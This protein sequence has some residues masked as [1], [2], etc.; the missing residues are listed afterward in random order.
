[1]RR[2]EMHS[3]VFQNAPSDWNEALPLGNGTFG[4]MA[5]FREGQYW[6]ALNHY[7]V[8]YT[9]YHRYSHQ[10]EAERRPAEPGAQRAQYE[11]LME[12]SRRNTGDYGKEEYLHYR[13]T[14][15]PTADIPRQSDL[16]SGVSHP[17][18]GETAVVLSEALACPEEYS[19]RLDIEEAA[20]RLHAQKDGKQVK[21]E[22]VVLADRS[23]ACTRVSQ[24]ESGLTEKLLLRY[25]QRRGH[26]GFSVRWSQEG[27]STFL[28]RV[29]FYPE[30]E[31]REQ[32]PPFSFAVVHHLIGAEGN[33]VPA[34]GGLDV[35]LS[36]QDREYILLS[37]AATELSGG[38]NPAEAALEEV[39]NA[40]ASLT[41]RLKAHRDYWREFFG[42]SAVLLPDKV[43]ERLWYL[44]LYALGCCS[45]RKGCRKEQASGLNGLWDIR[46]PTMWGSLWYWDVNIE[47]TY[48]PV[49]T[50][51]HLELAE[52]FHDGF[53][54]YTEQAKRRAQE[55]YGMRGYAMDYP[56][57]FYNCM[58]PWCAQ[59]LWWYYEY[60]GDLEFLRE[61]AYPV[62]Y[63]L[64][65]FTEDV[66][67]YDPDTGRWSFFP[68]VSPEQG[69]ITRN[70]TIT[71]A[72]V[73]YMLK[74]ALQACRLLNRPDEEAE[75]FRRLLERM[76]PYSTAVL[77]RYGEVLKDSELAPA[78]LR[79]RH[80]SL[81]MPIFPLSELG[82]D[83]GGELLQIAK[84][85]VFFA[86]E[87]T[88]IGVFPFGWIAAAAARLGMGNTALRILYEQ[89]LDL[90]L[91]ANGMGAEET[92]RWVNKCLVNSVHFYPPFMMEC[93][94]EIV[95]C[96]NEM[97][98]Q[99]F[100]GVIRLFPAV[101]NGD[102]EAYRYPGRERQPSDPWPEK[103][104]VRWLACGF[105][106]LLAKGG[107]EVSAR[108]REG[109]TVWVSIRSLRGG[110]V[111]LRRNSLPDFPVVS[112]SGA[113]AD[114]SEKDGVLSF[115]T[116][117][118]EVYTMGRMPEE[119][120]DDAPEVLC[121]QTH[122]GRKNYIG[123]DR[124]TDARK[125][126]DA[127]LCDYY[128][129]NDRY[130]PLIAY[131]FNFGVPLEDVRAPGTPQ[132]SCET[133]LK[134]LKITPG[135]QW[136]TFL[137]FGLTGG[138]TRAADSGEGDYLLR[139]CLEG[140]E[141]TSFR[142]E[143][144]KGRYDLLAVTGSARAQRRTRFSV[145]SSV[146]EGQTRA[147]EFQAAILPVVH[148]QDGVLELR[149]EAPSPD[150]PW[151]LNLLVIRKIHAFL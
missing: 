2:C 27:P 90:I 3:V 89:G 69:P 1:M 42:K 62:F 41:E 85:T 131:R 117:P 129:S 122:L 68:D 56:H 140:T 81:L 94:G 135:L 55:F 77:D 73:K 22:T 143:L 83:S 99:D 98:M 44:N 97:L 95:N 130:H 125:L 136:N 49:Y 24:S 5:Y 43:L 86:S 20:V 121:Y 15:W 50:A 75:L 145:G 113:A 123:K 146:W 127:F 88:E 104:P 112:S 147:G 118:G 37:C 9:M 35:S 137:G 96:V 126:L 134:F 13:R 70:S 31:D 151:S 103:Q 64:A 141:E 4:G 34:E 60:S 45:G 144:P 79:L 142:I 14:I 101:P 133:D 76:P 57:D 12:A 26:E 10:A 39:R 52:A 78:G 92:D 132:P 7:E 51:N 58:W 61:K 25:P 91:R 109:R 47:S 106:R 105:D 84:N 63:N 11:A 148:L 18:T 128:V 67:Q 87:N 65:L 54:S 19:L 36:R 48:W 30:G 38:E 116:E 23:C 66:L 72:C 6:L 46:Q 107:F 28:C 32:F 80:P 149:V 16:Q 8:Y 33:A 115:R 124:N 119:L 29:S 120:P 59:Y 108:M 71:I 74:A 40:A 114:V 138:K 21:A 102:P 139:D 82:P 100:D 150:M 17:P 110:T 111:R 93:V 53:L